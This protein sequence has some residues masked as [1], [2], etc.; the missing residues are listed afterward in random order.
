MRLCRPHGAN[1]TKSSFDPVELLLLLLKILNMNYNGVIDRPE[2]REAENR[3]LYM[4]ISS[5]H[6]IMNTNN[7]FFET[8]ICILNFIRV[9]HFLMHNDFYIYNNVKTLSLRS[10]QSLQWATSG[11]ITISAY[12]HVSDILINYIK[13]S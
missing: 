5:H 11:S 12:V 6:I 7:I 8:Y 1:H 9:C 2:T 10:T 3:C 13:S 4:C